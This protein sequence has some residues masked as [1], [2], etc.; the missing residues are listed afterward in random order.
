MPMKDPRTRDCRC[1]MIC[2]EPL[3]LTV[4]DGANVLRVSRQALT[5]LVNG[6][7][8]IS[9]EMAIRLDMAFG[10][11][12]DAWL[13]LQSAYDLAQARKAARH[14]D[15]KRYVARH[16]PREPRSA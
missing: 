12:A 2:L 11:T 16:R 5:S 6:K 10:G 3:G 7:A 9:P 8:G 4:T 1:A 15:V 13:A 14:I